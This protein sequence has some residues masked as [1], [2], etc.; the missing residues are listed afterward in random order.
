[1]CVWFDI[2]GNRLSAA[3]SRTAHWESLFQAQYEALVA[4][5]VIPDWK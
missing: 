5:G 4:T 3:G 1:M 2:E